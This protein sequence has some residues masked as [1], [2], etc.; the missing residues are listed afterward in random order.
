MSK[1]VSIFNRLSNIREEVGECVA[2]AYTE[3]L[4]KKAFF[5]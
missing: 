1:M 4:L 5:S 3:N 2:E